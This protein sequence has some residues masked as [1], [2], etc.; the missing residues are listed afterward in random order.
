MGDSIMKNY[1]DLVFKK[2]KR[3][4]SREKLYQ[5]VERL[6]QEEDSSYLLS[7]ED[8]AK[9]DEALFKGV[10]DRIYF[11]TENFF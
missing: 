5:K 11:F 1:I 3:A 4:I 2:E 7:F 10:N 8:K 6:I 9:I